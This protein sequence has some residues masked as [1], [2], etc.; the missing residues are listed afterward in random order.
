M[1]QWLFSG[2][3]YVAMTLHNQWWQLIWLFLFG[4]ISFVFVPKQ[5]EYVLGKREERWNWL[6]AVIMVIPYVIWAGYRKDFGDSE[7]YR[8]TFMN[9]PSS[10]SQIAS[11][12]SGVRK[13]HAFR[14]FELLFKCLVSRSSISLFLCIAAIQILCLVHVYRKYS[15]NYWL[16]MF[17][18]VASTDYLTWMQNGIRQFVAVSILFLCIPL[19]AQKRYFPVVI[20]TLLMS[21]IHATALIFLPFIFIV[22]GRAWNLRTLLFIVAM[23]G[24]V[25]FVDR[26]TGFLEQALV[27]TAYEGDIDIL[28]NNDGT[29]IIRV[30][31]YSV[32]AIMCWF[33]RSNLD[34]AND[35]LLNVCANLSIVTT[36][37]Y[38][39]S[40]FTSGILMGAV[41]IYFSLSNYILI[42]WLLRE[43]FN[44]DST[45]LL[46]SVFAIVYMA[47]F[48]YQC[49]PTWGVL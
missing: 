16:S 42:P 27:D 48:Y 37:F 28:K 45:V 40:F 6:P 11:Y 8:I 44:R 18:F 34:R 10:L 25:L 2:F 38:V 24:A 15:N 9:L 1:K 13:G 7:Q 46:E 31:F 5:T 29:N 39:F 4:G 21:Q 41:P 33:F 43:V 23:V 47:F 35:P 12:M 26:I 49:G 36:G 17:L 22:N 20:V 14:L 3:E 32:P 30:L 19:I